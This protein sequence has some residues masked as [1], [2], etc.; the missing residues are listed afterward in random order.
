MNQIKNFPEK[1]SRIKKDETD[2]EWYPTDS[3]MIEAVFKDV[4]T[5]ML[6]GCDKLLDIGAGDGNLFRMWDKLV[7]L[8]Y[9]KDEHGYRPNWIYVPQKYYAIEKSHTLLEYLPKNIITIGTDI[10]VQTLIDKE[11]DII[12]CNP[13]YSEFKAWTDKI[14]TESNA[15]VIYLVI[16]QCWKD[17]NN[18]KRAIQKRGAFPKVIYS[19]NFLDAPRAARAKIDIVRID[20][21]G[22]FTK[23]YDLDDSKYAKIFKESFREKRGSD[24]FE[25]WFTETFGEFKEKTV[26]EASKEHPS[27]GFQDR[28]H[29]VK[30]SNLMERLDSMYQEDLNKIWNIYKSLQ[31]V[32][33]VLFKELKISLNNIKETLKE[34]LSG[35]KHLYW[36]ELFDNLN[37]ITDRLTSKSRDNLLNTLQSNTSVDFSASN[38]Y[39]IVIWA[40]K[41]A[42]EYFDKQLIEAYEDLVNAESVA[43]YK[44]NSHFIKDNWRFSERNTHYYLNDK[45]DYRIVTHKVGGMYDNSSWSSYDRHGLTERAH[46]YIQDLCTIASNLGYDVS[47]NNINTQWVSGKEKIVYLKLPGEYKIGEKTPFGK[48][49]DITD[50]QYCI[51]GEWYAKIGM[52]KIEKLFAVRAFKNGNLH[53]KFNQD[54]LRKFNV[55]F[56][57]LKGWINNKAEA[58]KEMEIPMEK[59]DNFF[60][61]NFQIEK[62]SDVLLLEDVV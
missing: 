39:A 51:N 50:T 15:I 40:V 24:P 23:S 6:S 19:G 37:K 13:P 11:M 48:I 1:L 53:F 55:E 29:L 62:S 17:S 46:D 7:D 38:A 16:P 45:L 31:N 52:A 3:K 60:E 20:L 32:D 18:I 41:N 10:H 56:G 22:K 21:R 2:F 27:N 5:A 25:L 43:L 33:P 61:C 4:K 47:D 54:F 26:S 28:L 9:P 49:T 14:I 44:S 34:K 42:N 30:G 8:Y 58:A 12:F 35:L 36:K 57:R 59:I